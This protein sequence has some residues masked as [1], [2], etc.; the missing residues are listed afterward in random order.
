MKSDSSRRSQDSPAV[1]EGC[2]EEGG[3]GCENYV[4]CAL[5]GDGM[6]GKTCLTLSYTQHFFTDHYTATVFD[7]YSG[8]CPV[9][10]L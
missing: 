5:L 4:H 9:L 6:V 2:R 3:E 10:S 7:N 1:E 8:Q